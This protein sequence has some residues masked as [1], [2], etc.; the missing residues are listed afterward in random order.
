MNRTIRNLIVAAPLATIALTVIPVGAATA[1]PND[2]DLPIVIKPKGGDPL[3]PKPKFDDDLPLKP[4]PKPTQ[5]DPK[6]T[7]PAPKPQG[8][9]QVVV[10]PKAADKTDEVT[11]VVDQ[12]G[13]L[14][15]AETTQSSDTSDNGM[16][17][18]WLLVGGGVVTASGIAFAARK[19]LQNS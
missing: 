11:E 15:P 10:P 4:A 3:P 18:T 16:D 19:R 13:G 9:G 12:S 14:T 8:G 7:Q 6:P 1:G 2:Q 17:L 5:P